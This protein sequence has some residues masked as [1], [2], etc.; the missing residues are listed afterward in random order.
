MGCKLRSVEIPCSV[1]VGRLHED[2]K[3]EYSFYVQQDTLVLPKKC[4]LML[5]NVE[6]FESG[7]MKI[8]INGSKDSYGSIISFENRMK[9]SGYCTGKDVND[10]LDELKIN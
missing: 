7:T 6:T 9:R 2:L 5:N 8:N 10:L 1:Q 3:L 4:V